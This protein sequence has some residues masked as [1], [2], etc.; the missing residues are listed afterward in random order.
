MVKDWRGFK[1]LSLCF[2]NIVCACG[3]LCQ[4]VVAF[5][6][7]GRLEGPSDRRA[8]GDDLEPPRL[9]VGRRC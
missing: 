4:P 5:A 2:N 3:Q 1:A 8:V 6:I 7:A 9:L